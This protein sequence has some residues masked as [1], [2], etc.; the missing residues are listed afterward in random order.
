MAGVVDRDLGLANFVRAMGEFAEVD[1]IFSLVGF[2]GEEQHPESPATLATIAMVL[3]EGSNDGRI[4]PRPFLA[5]TAEQNAD[6]YLDEIEAVTQHALETGDLSVALDD[7]ARLGLV[8]VADVQ[9]TM[10]AFDDPGNAES[11]IAR[12]GADNPL[13]DTGIL[14]NAVSSA[15]TVDVLDGED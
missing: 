14:I 2:R 6:E 15:V 7:M 9:D 3:H 13:I 4:P 8:V 1:G 11:T 10:E 12:K 5:M